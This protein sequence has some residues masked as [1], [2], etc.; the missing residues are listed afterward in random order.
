ML[1]LTSSLVGQDDW[2][3]KQVHVQL[4]EQGATEFAFSML[5]GDSPVSV[6]EVAAGRLDLALVNPATAANAALRRAGLPMDALASIATIPSYDQ[7]GLAVATS[8]GI[9]RLEE[10]PTARPALRLTLR[11]QRDHGVQ[12][13]V[14]DALGAVGVTLSDITDWGGTIRYDPGLP[15]LPERAALITSGAVDAVFDEGVYNWGELAM[16]NGLTFL[17]FEEH[18]LARLEGL[19][20]R[21]GLL[22]PTRFPSLTRSIPTLDFS[23]FLLYTRSN[24]PDRFVAAICAALLRERDNIAWQGGDSLPLERMLSNAMDA[25]LSIPLHPAARRFW[26]ENGFQVP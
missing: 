18:T 14:V 6:P 16:A 9:T 21:R 17:S 23:G 1:Q 10:L 2:P 22:T 8:V 24:A 25:P 19:G 15:H 3:E 12:G 4:R 11:A 5:G 13:F 26:T 7:L 20:Y